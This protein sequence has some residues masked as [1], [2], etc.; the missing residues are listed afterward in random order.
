M[1]PNDCF[2]KPDYEGKTECDGIN[3]ATGIVVVKQPTPPLTGLDYRRA[4]Y[5]RWCH[6]AGFTLVEVLCSLAL[7]TLVVTTSIWALSQ[8]NSTATANRIY[9]CAETLAQNEIDA[10]LTATPYSPR[11]IAD[12]GTAYPR[13]ATPL[14][15]G[16]L[17]IVA[18]GTT[19]IVIP[20]CG[21]T[22]T[23]GCTNADGSITIYAD[24]ATWTYP[25]AAARTGATGF[26]AS[27]IGKIAYQS[28]NGTYWRLTATTPAWISDSSLLVKSNLPTDT[29]PGFLRTVADLALTQT[30]GGYTDSLDARRLSVTINYVFKGTSYTVALSTVRTSDFER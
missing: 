28:D 11:H 24:P 4:A 15:P 5:I 17:T 26:V 29:P 30:S 13:T 14:V 21:G 1:P 6:A 10:F 7:L 27:D 18:N 22:V 12:D 19:P 3:P 25:N 9:T 20:A 8:M 2:P 23:S 16:A